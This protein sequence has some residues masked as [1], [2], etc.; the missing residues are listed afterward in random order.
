MEPQ[1]MEIILILMNGLDNF[2]FQRMLTWF[3]L[4]KHAE[5][6]YWKIQLKKAEEMKKRNKKKQKNIIKILKHIMNRI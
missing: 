5:Q 4:Y 6:S 2:L 1:S 3:L